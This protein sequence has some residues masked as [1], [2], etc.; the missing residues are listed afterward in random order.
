MTKK[1]FLKYANPSIEDFNDYIRSETKKIN[2]NILIE[3][4]YKDEIKQE[5][6]IK[7][8]KPTLIYFDINTENNKVEV[9]NRIEE[10]EICSIQTFGNLTLSEINN[11]D[12]FNNFNLSQ[13]NSV[14]IYIV[15]LLIFE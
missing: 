9:I 3:N 10:L 7:S 12:I 4:P 2:H 1:C 5:T 14:Y 13:L 15:L 11:Y 6:D 8:V